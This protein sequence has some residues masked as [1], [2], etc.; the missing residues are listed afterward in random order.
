MNENAQRSAKRRFAFLHI[1]KTGGSAIKEAINKNLELTGERKIA[2]FGHR[3]QLPEIVENGLKHDLCFTVRE[4]VSRFISGFNSRIR[5][6]RDGMH[7]WKPR[8]IPVFERF[9]SPNELAEALSS[10]DQATRQ[11]AKAAMK[12]I[13]H[14]K[15]DLTHHFG[16]VELL[17]SIRDRI[18]FIGHLPSLDDDFKMFRTIVGLSADVELPKDEVGAHKAPDTVTLVKKL[19]PLGEEN[20]RKHYRKDYPIYEWCLKRREELV[21][22]FQAANAGKS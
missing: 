19:S 10:E 7:G 5:G 21:A 6:G 17:E 22:A 14:L 1:G 18:V 2:V 11:A 4:P 16:S 20:V 3:A 8:E 13:S 15:R 12:S 9:A